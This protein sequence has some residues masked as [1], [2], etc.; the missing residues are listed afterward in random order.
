MY[1]FIG[2]VH[3]SE[4]MMIEYCI[5]LCLIGTLIIQVLIYKIMEKEG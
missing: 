5:Y 4:N 3:I 2:L 1:F